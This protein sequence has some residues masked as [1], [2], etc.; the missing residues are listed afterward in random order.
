MLQRRHQHHSGHGPRGRVA[1][2]LISVAAPELLV[3]PDAEGLIPCECPPSR[4]ATPLDA[5][6][7]L[8]P[9]GLLARAVGGEGKT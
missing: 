5:A 9:M 2:A 6:K 1:L 3:P 7:R 8:S 4:Q